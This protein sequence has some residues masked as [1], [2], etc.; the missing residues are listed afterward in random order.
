MPEIRS[1]QALCHE[2]EGRLVALHDE[3]EQMRRDSQSLRGVTPRARLYQ[4]PFVDRHGQL[5]TDV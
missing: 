4:Q 3:V 2:R 1:V 5:A